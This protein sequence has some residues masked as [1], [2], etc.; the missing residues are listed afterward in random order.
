M[1]E[2]TFRDEAYLLLAIAIV[3]QAADDYR[4]AYRR[5]LRNGNRNEIL[6][7]IEDWMLFGDGTILSLNK[8]AYILKTIREEEDEKHAKRAKRK[9]CKKL[10]TYNGR[11][12]SIQEWADELNLTVKGLRNRMSRKLPPEEIFS[13]SKHRATRKVR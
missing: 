12:Q 2:L 11:T 13:P 6:D 4:V 9:K 7:E 8:G 3:K 10:Y 5:F 1:E